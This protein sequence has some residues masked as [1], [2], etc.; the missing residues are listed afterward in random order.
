MGRQGEGDRIGSFERSVTDRFRGI[1][2]PKATGADP[3]ARCA[4][5]PWFGA[6]ARWWWICSTT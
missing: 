2:P 1:P 5:C 4:A 3:S 6:S